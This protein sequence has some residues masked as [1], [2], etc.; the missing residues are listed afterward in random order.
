[1]SK[2]NVLPKSVA[3]LIAAGEVVERP[4]SVIKELVENSIDAGATTITV[5][6]K[7][8][9]IT[10]M[11]V[12]DNGKGIEPEDVS[13]AFLRHATSKIKT[14]T[15]LDEIF[16]LG[17]RG[18]ALAAISSVS[19]VEMLTK[20]VD[21]D[22]GVH[23]LIAGGEE[24][25]SEE[26]GC[27]N[28]TTL[29]I[30]DLFFNTPARM[31][32]M[33]KDVAESNAV[34][35]V[36]DRIA[37]SHPEISIKFIRDG[38]VTLNTNGN[39]D[40]MSAIYEVCKKEFASGLIP[41]DHTLNGIRVSGFVSKPQS[42]RPSHA[43]Q[44]FFLNGRSIKS[45]S[46]TAAVDNAYKN[47]AM[48]GRFPAAI[49]NIT[50]PAGTVDVNVHPAKTE[51]R[52]SDERKVFDC[53]MF[54]VRNAILYRDE[55][56]TFRMENKNIT[57]M[58]AEE[59]TQ[60]VINS[61]PKKQTEQNI[62]KEILKVNS[63]KNEEESTLKFNSSNN[64]SSN[65]K[66]KVSVDIKVEEEYE[67]SKPT[68][69]KPPKVEE[70]EEI[71][72]E[73]KPI[74]IEEKEIKTEEKEIDVKFIGEV[75]LTYIIVESG[76]SIYLIDKHAA[77]E[78]LIFEDLKKNA[79]ISKQLLLS[80]ETVNLPKEIYIDFIENL[81]LVNKSGF[82]VED[83][84]DGAVIVRAVPSPLADENI[85]NLIIEIAENI[86]KKNKFESEKLDWIFDN[87]SCRAAIKAGNLT[88]A[89]ELEALAKRVINNKDIMYCP[90]GR[91][92]AYKLT[93]KEIEKQFGRLG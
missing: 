9:G 7:N 73:E 8:G 51:V 55:R 48:V 65:I 70:K 3:E 56:P 60:T 29:I 61:T 77:H 28:G 25:L 80:A 17:F 64:K 11:R 43:G 68:E 22:Y 32:F 46:I 49:L 83:F 40:L 78:R 82:E 58:S 88:S 30:K 63:K 50:V 36:I 42:C 84:G 67:N 13:T 35:A 27:P 4:A 37:L 12:T 16:T 57:R 89:A 1:M 93:K 21:N 87:V 62:Y 10:F 74:K 53:V 90:H 23:Y 92:V 66:P 24:I 5:E 47:S 79:E 54:G 91:P 33:R 44:I 19:R 20:T 71:K 39:G 72:I 52:F 2:I 14:A 41:V 31:K 15:D 6:I 59:Y 45:A 34:A 85:D 75:F 81:S 76:D 26:T 18:E 86:S 38:K 69:I